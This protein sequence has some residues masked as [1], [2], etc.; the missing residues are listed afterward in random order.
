MRENTDNSDGHMS[1]E[2]ERNENS[3]LVTLN[4][5]HELSTPIM[6]ANNKVN[7]D[8]PAQTKDSQEKYQINYEN[9]SF[10]DELQL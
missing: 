10:F 4:E 1:D 6:H 7:T 2:V 8:L 5:I 9:L 3:F